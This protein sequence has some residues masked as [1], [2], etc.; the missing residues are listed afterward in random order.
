MFRLLLEKKKKIESVEFGMLYYI[1]PSKTT[2][3][4]TGFSPKGINHFVDLFLSKFSLII[5][6]ILYS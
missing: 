1:A 6:N 5:F 4:T 2:E 3:S